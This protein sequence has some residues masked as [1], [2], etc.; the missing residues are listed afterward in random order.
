M[1]IKKN[2]TE[3][4]R[5]KSKKKKKTRSN[6]EKYKGQEKGELFLAKLKP[7]VNEGKKNIN[8]SYM[9]WRK[10][11]HKNALHALHKCPRKLKCKLHGKNASA[12]TE[13]TF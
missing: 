11:T 13:N 6:H 2:G 4:D 9:P 7:I 12:H 8:A 1:Y 5:H 10:S 3:R